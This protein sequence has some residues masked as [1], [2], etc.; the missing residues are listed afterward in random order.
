MLDGRRAEGRGF[1]ANVIL[2]NRTT[3]QFILQISINSL[4]EDIMPVCCL[5]LTLRYEID[6]KRYTVYVSKCSILF[7][8]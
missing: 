2:L 7:K 1:P 4:I 6:L 8:W 3:I 5:S